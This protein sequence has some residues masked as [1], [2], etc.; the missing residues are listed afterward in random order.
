[1]LTDYNGSI[2]KYTKENSPG[3]TILEQSSLNIQT[4][5]CFR[6][7]PGTTSSWLLKNRYS[8]R[9]AHLANDLLMLQAQIAPGENDRTPLPIPKEASNSWGCKTPWSKA[10]QSPPSCQLTSLVK[11]LSPADPTVRTSPFTDP[12]QQSAFSFPKPLYN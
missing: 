8:Q 12:F 7:H 6:I 4:L 10:I 5:S 1:M 2:E 9:P 11:P 3:S